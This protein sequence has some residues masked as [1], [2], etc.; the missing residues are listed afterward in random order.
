VTTWE[1]KPL[2]GKGKKAKSKE[3]ASPALGKATRK[4]KYFKKKKTTEGKWR[5]KLGGLKGVQ[6]DLEQERALI[7]RES[8][9]EGSLGVATRRTDWIRGKNDTARKGGGKE[10]TRDTNTQFSR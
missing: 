7:C 1:E 2:I 3:T 10:L 9:E 6:R 4:K 8:E 5:R